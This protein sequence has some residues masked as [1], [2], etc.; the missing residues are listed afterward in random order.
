MLKRLYDRMIEI[1]AGPNAVLALIVVAFVESS[2]F[3]IPP[4]VLLIPMMLAQPECSATR[5]AITGS[6]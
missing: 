6:I 4:D 5:S 1:A 3:P 2:V